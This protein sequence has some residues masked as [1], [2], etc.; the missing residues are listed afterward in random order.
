MSTPYG[1]SRRC[2]ACNKRWPL[3]WSEK[4]PDDTAPAINVCP[5]CGRVAS[6]TYEKPDQTVRQAAEAYVE[7][8]CREADVIRAELGIPTPEE[9][10]REEGRREAR[11]MRLTFERARRSGLAVDND[12]L[13]ALL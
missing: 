2:N 3:D 13:E 9:V 1:N 5:R 4:C 6:L 12:D 7:R 11:R 10:G 8:L